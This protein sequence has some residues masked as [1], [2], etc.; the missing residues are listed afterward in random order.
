MNTTQPK[1]VSMLFGMEAVRRLHSL[2][3]APVSRWIQV[4]QCLHLGLVGYETRR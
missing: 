2:R 4:A 3:P 1:T